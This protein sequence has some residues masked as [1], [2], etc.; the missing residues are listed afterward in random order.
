M[1]L[2]PLLPRE[3]L[4][5]T[6]SPRLQNLRQRRAAWLR[7]RPTMSLQVVAAPRSLLLKEVGTSTRRGYAHQSDDARKNERREYN[8]VCEDRGSHVK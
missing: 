5:A 7:D 6:V 1:S 4:G 8:K 3:E 2:V